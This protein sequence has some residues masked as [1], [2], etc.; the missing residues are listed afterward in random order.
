MIGRCK[1]CGQEKELQDSHFLPKGIYKRMRDINEKNPNP[2]VLS[3]GKKPVQTSKQETAYLLCWDCEQRFS[4][5]GENWVLGNCRQQ[6]GSF[7]LKS[8]LSSRNPDIE[9]QGNPTR[10]FY[11]S[12]IPEISISEL[13]YF[14]ASIFWRGS[15][16]GWNNDLS[17]TV[18]LG[19]FQNHIR[20]Y[21]LGLREFPQD[22]CLLVFVR[23]AKESDAISYTPIGKRTKDYHVYKFPIPGLAFALLVS[24]N[25]PKE[26][27]QLCLVHGPG[28]PIIV[29][30]IIDKF[31]V[32]E[33]L[34]VFRNDKG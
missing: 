17:A 21:L 10:L 2:W 34:K 33:T 31:I 7:P 14:A 11:S 5:N 20:E 18:N 6:D 15:V 23:D 12:N 4:T 29:T 28:N 30:S 13:A 3:K 9:A 24:K 8:I 25:I 32:E 19:P 1:L 16:Y 26:Y 27:C 22:C